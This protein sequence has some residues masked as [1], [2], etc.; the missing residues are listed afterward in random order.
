MAMSRAVGIGQ[1]L[2]VPPFDPVAFNSVQACAPTVCEGRFESPFP[3]YQTSRLHLYCT[4]VAPG[5]RQQHQKGSAGISAHL[6]HAPLPSDDE[7]ATFMHEASY[8]GVSTSTSSYHSTLVRF[9]IGIVDPSHNIA[10]TV[11]IVNH[12]DVARTGDDTEYQPHTMC[13]AQTP[14]VQ[15]LWRSYHQW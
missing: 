6:A 4:G 9:L 5:W 15:V 13:P 3:W 12:A 10:A 2:T 14:K 1:S 11:G 8:P 7:S